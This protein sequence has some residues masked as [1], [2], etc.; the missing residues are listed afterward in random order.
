[1]PLPLPLNALDTLPVGSCTGTLVGRA[2][3]QA[4][5]ETIAGPSVIPRRL[6]GVFEI[7]DLAPTMSGLLELQDPVAAIRQTK[8]RILD[9]LGSLLTNK[10]IKALGVTFA[11][12]LIERVIEKRAKGDPWNLQPAFLDSRLSRREVC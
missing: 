4:N 3:V 1:M 6:E 7:N 5:N 2:R 11:G 12:S 10:V 9:S 8:G